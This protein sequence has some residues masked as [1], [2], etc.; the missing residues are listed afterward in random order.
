LKDGAHTDFEVLKNLKDINR[1]EDLRLNFERV[2]S[3]VD[4]L[5]CAK[6]L[7]TILIHLHT[8]EDFEK[9]DHSKLIVI[10]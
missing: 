3:Q 10:D 8:K 4:N 7:D 5:E 6:K 1:L 2:K 9:L